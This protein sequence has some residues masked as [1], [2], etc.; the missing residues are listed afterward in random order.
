MEMSARKSVKKLIFVGWFIR[1][2]SE[3]AQLVTFSGIYTKFDMIPTKIV[4]MLNTRST[5]RCRFAPLS[6]VRVA[7]PY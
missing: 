7:I 5:T 6:S 4:C 3:R 1:L 2:F